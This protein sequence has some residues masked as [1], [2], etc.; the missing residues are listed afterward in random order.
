MTYININDIFILDVN[1]WKDLPTQKFQKN[2]HNLIEDISKNGLNQPIII[3]NIDNNI[4]KIIDGNKRF[5][6]FQQLN[7][8]EISCCIINI[9]EKNKPKHKNNRT[10][11][12]NNKIKTKNI[13][14]TKNDRQNVMTNYYKQQILCDL[15][16]NKG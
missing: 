9:N 10:T 1:F 3:S 5:F 16:S 15:F 2:I 14:S 4:Y 13:E 8:N 7:K 11:T 12:K 6:A